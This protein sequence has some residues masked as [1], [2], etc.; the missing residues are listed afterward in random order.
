MTSTLNKQDREKVVSRLEGYLDAATAVNGAFREFVMIVNLMDIPDGGIEEA[1]IEHV[2]EW[3]PHSFKLT[4]LSQGARWTDV[5]RF[6]RGVLLSEPFGTENII[7]D[8]RFNLAWQATDMIMFLSPDHQPK[9][10]YNFEMYEEK[11]ASVV[12]RVIEYDDDLLLLTHIHWRADA[13]PLCVA[14]DPVSAVAPLRPV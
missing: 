7:A 10:I 14:D 9:C 2:A 1:I 3:E 4:S 11:A 5:E 8:R 13:K 6:L 12:G